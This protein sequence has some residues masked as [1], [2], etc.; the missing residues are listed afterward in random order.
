MAYPNP[1]ATIAAEACL[2]DLVD[3]LEEALTRRGFQRL[4]GLGWGVLQNERQ[5]TEIV[6]GWE[7][8]TEAAAA[9]STMNGITLFLDGRILL[10]LDRDFSAVLYTRPP[11]LQRPGSDPS[12]FAEAIGGLIDRVDITSG[13]VVLPHRD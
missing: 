10:G 8:D 5:L 3:E 11:T 9:E 4:R 2:R 12:M 6:A 1:P 13:T 7:R